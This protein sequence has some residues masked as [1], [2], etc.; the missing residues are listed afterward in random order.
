[1]LYTVRKKIQIKNIVIKLYN[2][3]LFSV[4]IVNKIKSNYTKKPIL[5]LPVAPFKMNFERR[6][7]NVHI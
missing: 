3:S 6:A 4:L 5:I 1:M 2:L 7:L